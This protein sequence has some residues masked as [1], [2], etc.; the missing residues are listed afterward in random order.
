MDLGLN[1]SLSSGYKSGAQIARII[2][3]DWVSRELPCIACG[4]S[5]LDHVPANSPALDFSCPRCSAGYELKSKRTAFGSRLVDGEYGS[6]VSRLS[7]DSAPNFLLMRYD[8]HAARV[9]D[10]FAIHRG[11]LTPLAIERRP[12]L[13][14]TARRAGWV[15][16]VIDLG[17]LPQGA[18]VPI[19]RNG[20]PRPFEAARRD[21]QSYGGI[22]SLQ[23]ALR[24]WVSDV[25]SC[26]QRLPAG[27][28]T[29]RDVY[30]FEDDLQK[31]HPGNQHVRPKIRQQLQLLVAM[32]Y[33]Q[34]LSPGLYR[35]CRA[36]TASPLNGRARTP[37]G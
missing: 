28:F 21:W 26:V 13:P 18:V 12:P 17:R 30:H 14:P 31:S 25:L 6:L 37:F 9:Q 19:I 32:G 5:S 22:T 7:S 4:A 29:L 33:L 1:I 34:R 35:R 11:L 10:L 8:F 16:S 15:G 2:S 27:A 20:T 36:D 23:P 3:E 24:G